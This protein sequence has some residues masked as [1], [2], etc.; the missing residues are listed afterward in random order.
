MRKQEHRKSNLESSDARITGANPMSRKHRKSF[1]AL[2]LIAASL[3]I[4][5]SAQETNK[6]KPEPL[7]IQEQGSFAVGGS[8]TTAPGTFE[9]SV[10]AVSRG[11]LATNLPLLP[12]RLQLPIPVGVD[13]LL[14]PGEHVL[15]RDVADRTVQGGRCCSARRSPPPLSAERRPR[16]S[17]GTPSASG[18]R[19]WLESLFVT[20]LRDRHLLQQMPLGMA[21]FCSGV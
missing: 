7:T 6:S 16:R 1:I 9:T 8:V 14:T 5:A 13:L 3:F 19:P 18:R 12:R 17:R 4:S 15:R 10:L 2:W 20:Q 11:R 21:T